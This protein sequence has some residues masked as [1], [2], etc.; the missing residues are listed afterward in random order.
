VRI[1]AENHLPRQNERFFAQHLMANPASHLEKILYAH[2][3]HKFANVGVILRVRG[4][5]R[6]NGVVERDGE[7]FGMFDA[8]H[9]ERAKNFPNRGGIVVRQNDVGPRVHNLTRDDGRIS[10]RAGEGFFGKCFS[11]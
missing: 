5:G 9:A 3:V 1:R 8:R 6:G 2:F 4:S 7:P 10:R 11:V